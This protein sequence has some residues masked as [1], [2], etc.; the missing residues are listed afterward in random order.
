MQKA[1]LESMLIFGVGVGIGILLGTTWFRIAEVDSDADADPIPIPIP[2]SDADFRF[3]FANN[4]GPGIQSHP[5]AIYHVAVT[6]WRRWAD[7]GGSESILEGGLDQ[8]GVEIAPAAGGE[9]V[10]GE[11]GVAEG[12]ADAGES[13]RL[14]AA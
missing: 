12:A 10:A 8:V 9:I 5:K 7:C 13:W 2:I 11:V 3:I 1:E 4:S 6:P 14:M